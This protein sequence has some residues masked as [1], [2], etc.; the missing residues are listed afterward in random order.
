MST[1]NLRISGSDGG[2]LTVGFLEANVNGRWGAVCGAS[3]IV[4]WSYLSNGAAQ[5]ACRQ[6]GLPWAGATA[7][8]GSYRCGGRASGENLR[9]DIGDR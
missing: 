2:D 6:M 9:A 1:A 3:P 5:V 7:F 4:P 8:T